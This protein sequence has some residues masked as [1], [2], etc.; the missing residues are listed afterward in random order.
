MFEEHQMLL[1]LAASKH[2]T[3]V[4]KTR[5]IMLINQSSIMLRAC[6]VDG[7]RGTVGEL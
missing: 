4:A 7:N 2:G 6:S 5:F 3:C 1:I